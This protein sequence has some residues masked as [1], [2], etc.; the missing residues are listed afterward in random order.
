MAHWA[1]ALIGLPWV[2]GERDCW[3]FFRDVQAQQ[4]GRAVPAVALA[5]YSAQALIRA[6]AG[7]PERARWAQVAQPADG[8]AVLMG[9]SSRP[10]HVG[11]WVQDLGRVLHCA[12]GAGVLCQ[13]VAS[14]RLNGW[15]HITYWTP[16]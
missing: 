13:D 3:S 7:H 6:V 9:R 5:D 14:L 16:R 11:V 8:D 12:E 15:G 2:A 1:E 4:Y 10:G